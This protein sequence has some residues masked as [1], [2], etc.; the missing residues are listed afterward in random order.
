MRFT[1]I[2]VHTCLIIFLNQI[3]A[4]GI[5]VCLR[6]RPHKTR[7]IYCTDTHSRFHWTEVQAHTLKRIADFSSSSLN[8]SGTFVI[9]I[10]RLKGLL[11]EVVFY[12]EQCYLKSWKSASIKGVSTNEYYE[13]KHYNEGYQHMGKSIINIQSPNFLYRY[14]QNLINI[15]VHLI[16]Q[17]VRKLIFFYN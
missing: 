6:H 14:T 10:N 1:Y 2:I 8:Y 3:N 17:Y 15:K 11:V 16:H 13:R 4:P 9:W 12:L 5:Y 7:F